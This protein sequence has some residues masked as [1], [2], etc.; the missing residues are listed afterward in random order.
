MTIQE[1]TTQ[2]II[3]RIAWVK[4]ECI[5]DT[6]LLHGDEPKYG[7]GGLAD[8]IINE[9]NE[10][11]EKHIEKLEEELDKRNISIK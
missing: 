5:V 6:W 2:H 4:R 3:N 11:W 1:M 8:S 7:A 9:E 10:A